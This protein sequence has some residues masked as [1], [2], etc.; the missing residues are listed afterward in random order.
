MQLEA[1]VCA[2]YGAMVDE[3]GGQTI[4]CADLDRPEICR[5]RDLHRGIVIRADGV[6]QFATRAD[7]AQ[8]AGE[9]HALFADKWR[10]RVVIFDHGKSVLVAASFGYRPAA[11]VD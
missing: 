3:M 5:T 11:I 10:A 2:V 7:G 9:L 1:D 8:F 4:E 6:E